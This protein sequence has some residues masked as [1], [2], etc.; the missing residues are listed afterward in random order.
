[1]TLS[2]TV[3]RTLACVLVAGAGIASVPAARRGEPDREPRERGEHGISNWF[4]NQRASSGPIPP[5]AR[6]SAL[7]DAKARG[8][9][10]AGPGTWVNQGPRNIGGRVTATAVD[11]NVPSHIW[12]GTADGGVFDSPDGG[13]TWTA[14]FDAQV[15][16]SIGSLAVHPTNSS[17]VYVGTGEDNG[18]GYSYD[19]EGVYK[20][21]DG[22]Q[23]WTNLGLAEVKRIGNIVID[24]NDPNRIFV[25]GGGDWFAKGTDRGVY[26]SIDGGAS[27]QNVLYV[28][29]DTG[30]IDLEIDPSNSNRIY[31]A[32][33][34]RFSAG[35][36]WYIGGSSSGIYRSTDGGT[37]WTKL[38]TGLPSANVGRI[39]LAIAPSAPATVY[40]CVIG[41]NGSLTGI[42]KTLNSGDQWLKVSGTNAPLFFSSYSYYFSQI[43]VDPANAN[44]LW[45]L[46]VNL[47]VSTNGGTNWTF[48]ATSVHSDVHDMIVESTGRQLLGTDGG[49]Y[50]S[51]DTGGTW[52][53]VGNLPITQFYDMGIDRL[54][55]A[56]RFAGAQ[57]N[58]VVRTT[59]GGL[60]DWQSVIGG[61]GL[62]VEVDPTNSNKVYGESQY[63]AIAR[64][65]DGGATFSSATTGI[66]AAD[67]TNWNTPIT[68]DPVVP[69]TLYTGTYRVYRSTDSA[70]SWT[71][72]SPNLTDA[73][74]TP[75]GGD[76]RSTMEDLR[77]AYDHLMDLIMHTITVVSLSPVD[78]RVLWV[79]TDDGLVWV[80]SN[81]GTSWTNV[82]PPGAHAWVTD[83]APDAFD[84][85]AAY[86]S[87]TGYRQGDKTPYLRATRDLGQSWQDLSGGLPQLPVDS[88]LSDAIWKGRLFA[89]TDVGVSWSDDGGATWSDLRGGMPYG[90]IMDLTEHG[91][92]NT[93]WAASYSRGLFTYD[94]AQLGT[95]DGD[96]DGVDNNTDCA[97]ADSGAFASPGEVPAL[98]IDKG[99]GNAA[100]LIWSNLAA[101]A[102]TGTAYDVA[103]GD[104]A[105]LAASG[106]GAATAL[107]CGVAGTTASDPAI[108]PRSSGVYY[109][110]RG[111]NTCGLGTWGTGTGGTRV[112]PACP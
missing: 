96:H 108:P 17:I 73:P 59:T 42:Y 6:S 65:V 104:L 15:A 11:P 58:N 14:R 103:R 30:A 110:V 34:Q 78:T 3:K 92:T 70:V 16:M 80:S 33:W 37:T 40:A 35:S 86:L 94:L 100:N 1:M 8:I 98:G 67:R 32:M 18:G 46:D 19:G 45:A 81:S 57:D 83:I 38:T 28:A 89:G 31:A 55:P 52:T 76:P 91:P 26:R 51:T 61:D 24:K 71:P 107:A 2:R 62:Q 109:L 63:G 77:H 20:T 7:S 22:G 9:L 48:T 39:G 101:Q 21:V 60:D 4:M 13:T 25:A 74:L 50:K 97:L 53:H 79:G 12:I 68:L 112:V 41:S 29:D 49:F 69:S 47:L 43:R 82:T 75:G 27:W 106:T 44:K 99:A 64:S 36:S 56:R 111:R 66:N 90:V 95:A 88:V 23:T 87:V 93:L 84:A 85:H 10:A 54:N 5:A 72:I 102:G 105:S